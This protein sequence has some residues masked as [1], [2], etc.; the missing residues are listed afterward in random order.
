MTN[1]S[2]SLLFATLLTFYSYILAAPPQVLAEPPEATGPMPEGEEPK[3]T[4]LVRDE[5]DKLLSMDTAI[6]RYVRADGQNPDLVVELVGAVHVGEKS[7]YE[8]LN[9]Q[10]TQYDALLFELVAPPETKIPKGGGNRSG[11]PVSAVQTGLKSLLGLEF[12]LE[13]IDY[14]RDNFVHADMS[15]DEFSRKMKEKNETFWTI[16]MRMMTQSMAQQANNPDGTPDLSLLLALVSKNREIKLKQA[17][18]EQMDQMEGAIQALEG[19]DGSTILTE[20]NK[21]ALEVLRREIDS[22]KKKVGIFYGAAHLP[23]MHR[24]LQ[25]EFGL[26]LVEQR[27]VPA[28]DLKVPPS[29]RATRKKKQE[30][31]PEKEENRIAP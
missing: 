4:R 5:N 20:R 18:A 6:A 15:P 2:R 16:F 10:F 12:Q 3:F 8:A 1:G 13:Q 27:W 28:W 31:P 24:R 9:S 11:N 14:T 7:Y 23:D 21:K 19:P 25:N 22:G 17:M 29:S 26:K 30:R